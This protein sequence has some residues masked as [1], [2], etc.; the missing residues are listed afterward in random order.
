MCRSSRS[1]PCLPSND[2]RPGGGVS[3]GRSPTMIRR[4]E[5]EA[6]EIRTGSSRSSATWRGSTRRKSATATLREELKLDSL[7]L[8]EIG[9]DVDSP[10]SSSCPTSATRRSTACRRWWTSSTSRLGEVA[11]RSRRR[12]RAVIDEIADRGDRPRP[13]HP[14]R[15]RA[16]KRCGRRCSRAAPASPRSSRSTPGRSAS[17]WEPRSGASTRRP[18]CG[19]R[20]RGRW[21]AP[22]NSPSPPPGRPWR[23][24]GSIPRTVRARA[25]R[26]GHGHHLGRAAGGRALRRPLPGRR[27]RPGGSGV[28]RSATP[29]T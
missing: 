25:G 1:F 20:I 29:A 4:R 27:A 21:A 8:L 18:G 24:P 11:R 23:T 7:S 15:R 3:P 6:P 19:A 16:R 26:G 9:V 10:S 17:T 13:G 22:R 28:H 12:R 2:S 14:G 5:M